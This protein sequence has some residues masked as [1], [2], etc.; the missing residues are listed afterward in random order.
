MVTFLPRAA[1]P[2][3]RG[4]A[5]SGSYDLG[6]DDM[7]VVSLLGDSVA[8]AFEPGVT[9]DRGGCS[10]VFGLVHIAEGFSSIY[11]PQ[12]YYY[13]TGMRWRRKVRSVEPVHVLPKIITFS[14]PAFPLHRALA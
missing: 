10:S 3:P 8:G 12:S 5:D 2:V 7:F 14:F 13:G 11:F 6:C 1:V 4:E 9:P